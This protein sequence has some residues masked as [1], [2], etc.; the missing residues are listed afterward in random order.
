VG[1]S[2]FPDDGPDIETLLKRADLAMY[3]TKKHGR[4]AFAFA[5]DEAE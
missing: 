3:R 5:V 4:S 1:I 2:V